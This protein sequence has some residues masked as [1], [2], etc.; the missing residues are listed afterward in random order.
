[1]YTININKKGFTLI[2]ILVAI[3]IIGILATMLLANFQGIRAR[4]RDAQRKRDLNELRTALRLF[5][6]DNQSYPLN[7]P[8]RDSGGSEEDEQKITCLTSGTAGTGDALDWGDAF[9]CGGTTYM[10]ELPEDPLEGHIRYYYE[11]GNN[12]DSFSLWACLENQ[13]DPDAVGCHGYMFACSSGDCFKVSA[14]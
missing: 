10:Q 14:N 4:A 1:M 2:E 12:G 8:N 5:Y 13:A 9:E 11:V 6:N 7:V 3:A